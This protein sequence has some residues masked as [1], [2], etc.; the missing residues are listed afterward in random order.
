LIHEDIE[1]GLIPDNS[2]YHS[3]QKLLS[4]SPLSKNVNI[5]T[6][7]SIISPVVSY[8]CETWSLILKGDHRLKIFENWVP[9][10]ICGQKRDEMTEEN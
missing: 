6:Y 1:G 5:K 10:R 7:K 8:G 9:R 4:S 2:C 3:V